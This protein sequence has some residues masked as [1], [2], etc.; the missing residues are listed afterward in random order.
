MSNK[1]IKTVFR[2]PSLFKEITLLKHLK[3]STVPER[4]YTTFSST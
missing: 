2:N 3:L 4:F 1:H